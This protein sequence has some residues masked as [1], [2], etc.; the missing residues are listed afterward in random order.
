MQ[1]ILFPFQKSTT[2][3]PSEESKDPAGETVL[4]DGSFAAEAVETL[5]TVQLYEITVTPSQQAEASMG[6]SSD[7]FRQTDLNQPATGVNFPL[8]LFQKDLADSANSTEVVVMSE[9]L[10]SGEPDELVAALLTQGHQLV[11][12]EST[13]GYIDEASLYVEDLGHTPEHLSNVQEGQVAQEGQEVI[14][15]FETIPNILPSNIFTQWNLP[16]DTV[17][18]SALSSEPIT[19][20][21]P[22]V[23]QRLPPSPESLVLKVDRGDTDGGEGDDGQSEED[24]MEWQNRQLEEHWCEPFSL[25]FFRIFN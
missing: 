14:T 2:A 6:E 21:L 20:T 10:S 19:S 17:L 16:P 8:A 11:V 7:C 3:D 23:S 22:I 9:C 1:F 25:E 15:Y 18:S 4:Q 5:H 13:L 24:S 12:D